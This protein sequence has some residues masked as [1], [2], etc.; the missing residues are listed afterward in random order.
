VGTVLI[1]LGCFSLASG[2]LPAMTSDAPGG[3]FV[4]AADING[5]RVRLAF[6]TGAEFSALFRPT[7]TRL[8]LKVTEWPS[9]QPVGPGKVRFGTAEPC[10]LTIWN[11]SVRATFAVLDL[12]VLP[13]VDGLLSWRDLS[14]NVIRFDGRTVTFLERVPPDAATWLKLPLRAGAATLGLDIPGRAGGT[15]TLEVDTGGVH[16]ISLN[17]REWRQWTATH[18]NR[19][20]TLE[21]H[22]MPGAGLRVQELTWA[23]EIS[24][25]PL[26]ITDVLLREATVTEAGMAPAYRA[27]LGLMA[28]GRLDLIVDGKS[29]VAYVR[30]RTAPAPPP[31]HNRLGAVFV[32]VDLEKGHDLVG[33]VLNDSPAWQAGIRDGDLL[34]RIGDTDVTNWWSNPEARAGRF[35]D[36]PAGTKLALT[37]RRGD[38]EFR[39]VVVLRDLIGPGLA[40][41]SGP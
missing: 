13:P 37:L 12:L 1:A 38:K 14:K 5:N 4:V 41:R 39:V 9:D 7:A 27:T 30:P 10:T 8:G 15:E 31:P 35:F 24:I 32:P 22:Y 23:D 33:I 19:P 20:R 36:S 28:V 18:P 21:A 2:Q 6:D 29:D 26:T 40:S 34:L 17:E 3:Y 11:K 16:G 25:G